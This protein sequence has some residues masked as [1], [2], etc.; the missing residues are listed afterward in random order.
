MSGMIRHII[1]DNQ[2]AFLLCVNPI[3]IVVAITIDY[4]ALARFL[5]ERCGNNFVTSRVAKTFVI[6]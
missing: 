4:R 2:N 5:R 6:V 1:G 3:E